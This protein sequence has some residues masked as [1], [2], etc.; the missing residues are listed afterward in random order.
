MKKQHLILA[1]SLAILCALIVFVQCAETITVGS[2]G[3]MTRAVRLYE[4]DTVDGTLQVNDGHGSLIIKDPD[5]QTV[6]GQTVGTSELNDGGIATFSFLAEKNGYYEIDYWNMAHQSVTVTLDYSVH[7]SASG[8]LQANAIWIIGVTLLGIAVGIILFWRS[9]TK[10]QKLPVPHLQKQSTYIR[11][12]G[13][14]SGTK[15]CSYSTNHVDA[16]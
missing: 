5:E 8:Y 15:C 11:N 14:P 1:V 9:R 16:T 4:G 6:V 7:S 2:W 12:L 10:K 13:N 3:H